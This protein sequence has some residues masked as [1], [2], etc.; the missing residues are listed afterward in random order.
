MRSAIIRVI[1]KLLIL[2]FLKIKHKGFREFFFLLM[3]K[4]ALLIASQI[5]K[6]VMVMI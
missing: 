3:L 6:F 1:I 2:S 5:R 4:S